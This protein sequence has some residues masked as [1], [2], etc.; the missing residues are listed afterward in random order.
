MEIAERVKKI[1]PSL[2]LAITAKAKAMKASGIDV[3]SFGAGEPNFNTP[4]YIIAAA[5][6]ALDKGMTKYTPVPGMEILRKA[7]AEKLSKELGVSYTFD[8]IVVSAGGKQT[9]R[10]AFETLLNPGDEVIIPSPFWLTYPE[11]VRLSGGECVF[12]ETDKSSD[13]KITPESL[14][15]AITKKTKALIFNSPSNPTGSVYTKEEIKAIANVV[16]K[17]G[18]YVISD[19]IYEKLVYG[20]TFSSIVSASPAMKDLTIICSGLSKSYSMTGWRV[21]YSA[22]PPNVAKAMS[23]L[24]SHTTSNVNSIAQYASYVALTDKRGEDFLKEM[25]SV[26]D[27]R[28]KLICSLVN[29]CELISCNEP[30]GAFYVMVDISKTFGKTFEGELISSSA[31]FCRLLLEKSLVAT[32]DGA[33]FGAPNFVRLS[34]AISDSDIEKG[35]KRIDEFLKKLK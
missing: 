11:L 29:S 18:I 26:F 9:L 28:R 21:G 16:E 10:N 30:K 20:E 6:E 23:S 8:Q 35:I 17:Y 25:I 13:F 27:R 31:D 3:V 4:D 15:K 33:A 32:V 34:Y 2:T 24:Q 12:V 19:E 7:I 5:K 1:S 22:A 14:E